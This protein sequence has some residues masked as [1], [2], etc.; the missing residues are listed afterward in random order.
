[1][2]LIQ[3]SEKSNTFNIKS[4]WPSEGVGLFRS[5]H[6]LLSGI[7]AVCPRL[8]GTCVKF[9]TFWRSWNSSATWAEP[10]CQSLGRSW[11]L[12]LVSTWNQQTRSVFPSQNVF[13]IWSKTLR[14]KYS[15]RHVWWI[16]MPTPGAMLFPKIGGWEMSEIA[17][18]ERVVGL[19]QKSFKGWWSSDFSW[20][21]HKC[22][23][24]SWSRHWLIVAIY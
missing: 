14:L 7:R 11:R 5:V 10:R 2:L 1:M 22:D 18:S 17:F 16:A 4:S 8:Q 19:D 20:R 15:F 6:G 12:L 24:L 23:G 21:I 13:W 9:C 3:K